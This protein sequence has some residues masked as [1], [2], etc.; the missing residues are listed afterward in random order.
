MKNKLKILLLL[1]SCFFLS[2]CTVEYNLNIKNAKFK[3]NILIQGTKEDMEQPYYATLKNWNIPSFYEDI[4]NNSD[5]PDKIKGVEYYKRKVNDRNFSVNLSYQFTQ[6]NY[7]DSTMA[8]FCYN[9]FFAYENEETKT[10]SYT[11]S[12]DFK[13]FTTYEEL[14]NV[15]VKLTTNRKMVNHNADSVD[16]KTYIWNIT[17]DNAEGKYIFFEL[18]NRGLT[19]LTILKYILIVVSILAILALLVIIYF[20]YRWMKANRI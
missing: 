5:N 2:G 13:C 20:R 15:V 6:N 16:G 1:C 10:I 4:I 12:M 19:F 7:T 3:E 18:D 9:N 14:D 8:K 17:R 11:A